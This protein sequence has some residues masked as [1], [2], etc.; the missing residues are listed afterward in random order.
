MEAKGC[1]CTNVDYWLNC[2]VMINISIYTI[3]HCKILLT[4]YTLL[5]NWLIQVLSILKL[6][7]KNTLVVHGVLKTAI[8]K[9]ICFN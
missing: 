8:W 4:L 5:K 9:F 7:R 1:L 3:K 2:M 6:Y